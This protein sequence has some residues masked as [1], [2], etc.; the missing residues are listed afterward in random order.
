VRRIRNN[1][2]VHDETPT[3]VLLEPGRY[4]VRVPTKHRELVEFVVEIRPVSFTLVEAGSG[5]RRYQS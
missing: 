3:E 4:V 1:I 2:G 5:P